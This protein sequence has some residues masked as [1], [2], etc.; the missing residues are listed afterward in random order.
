MLELQLR[1]IEVRL[2][3]AELDADPEALRAERGEL[4]DD[5]LAGDAGLVAAA[6]P[7]PRVS[8]PVAKSS[9]SRVAHRQLPLGPR[10]RTARAGPRLSGYARRTVRAGQRAPD[11]ARRTARAG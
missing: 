4:A 9:Q 7:G 2:T 3:A 6:G 11:S 1:D 8:Q 5:G 10:A